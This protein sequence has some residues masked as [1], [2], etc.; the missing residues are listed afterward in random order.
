MKYL[1]C[2]SFIN[3]SFFE[4]ANGRGSAKGAG[5]DPLSLLR[6]SKRSLLQDSPRHLLVRRSVVYFC[7]GAYTSYTG[8]L[9]TIG[10]APALQH[11]RYTMDDVIVAQDCLS[12][13]LVRLLFQKGYDALLR[14]SFIS[15]WRPYEEGVQI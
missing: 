7:S 12:P 1:Y 13:A 9:E 11:G 5:C 10:N 3:R 2:C 4:V 8:P 6:L 14:G 15:G